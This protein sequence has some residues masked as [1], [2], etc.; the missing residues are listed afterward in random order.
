M[1][2]TPTQNWT[3]CEGITLAWKLTCQPQVVQLGDAFVMAIDEH[4][5]PYDNVV[6]VLDVCFELIQV[7]S[8]N[9][10]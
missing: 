1:P 6:K 8:T 10:I 7:L 9:G 3:Q 5:W 2:K 4:R